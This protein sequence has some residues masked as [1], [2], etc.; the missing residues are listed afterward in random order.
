MKT[1][2]QA[3]DLEYITS[4]LFTTF[5][6]SSKAGEVAYNEMLSHPDTPNA[7]IY[8]IHLKNMLYQLKKA[9]YTVKKAKKISKKESEKILNEIFNDP[10]FN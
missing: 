1:K 9:G 4:G 7:K 8:T 6:P 3:P 2:K 10:M 5:L